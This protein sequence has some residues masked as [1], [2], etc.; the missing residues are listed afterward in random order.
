MVVVLVVAMDV[1][2]QINVTTN[3]NFF[4]SNLPKKDEETHPFLYSKIEI[5][6]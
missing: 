4:E 5:M 2:L 3:N 1:H 6:M